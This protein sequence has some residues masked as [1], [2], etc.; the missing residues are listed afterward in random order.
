MAKVSEGDPA[1]E[2][3][4]RVEVPSPAAGVGPLGEMP[5]YEAPVWLGITPGP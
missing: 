1:V 2:P 5:S 3:D 4:L